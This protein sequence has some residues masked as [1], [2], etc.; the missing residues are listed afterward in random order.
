MVVETKLSKQSGRWDIVSTEQCAVASLDALGYDNVTKG[1]W[2]HR[3][4]GWITAKLPNIIINYSTK[5]VMAK[6][7]KIDDKPHS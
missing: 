3:F 2:K 6:A 7:L 5:T 1:H 4:I